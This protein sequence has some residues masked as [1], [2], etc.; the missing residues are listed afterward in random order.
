MASIRGNLGPSFFDKHF[1]TVDNVWIHQVQ[2]EA[3]SITVKSGWKST[4][5]FTDP[6]AEYRDSA[7]EV[8]PPV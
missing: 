7:I 5:D 2:R 1:A 4:A 6:W 3:L 8:C